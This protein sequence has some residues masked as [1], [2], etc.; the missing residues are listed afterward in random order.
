[1]LIH[2]LR[3]QQIVP[4]FRSSEAVQ[5]GCDQFARPAGRDARENKGPLSGRQIVWTDHRTTIAHPTK[6][7]R[8]NV[9]ETRQRDA[10]CVQ[11]TESLPCDPS[12]APEPNIP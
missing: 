2:L 1:M 4:S 5:L 9:N 8:I 6:L 7:P 10:F 3:N 12:R 11:I